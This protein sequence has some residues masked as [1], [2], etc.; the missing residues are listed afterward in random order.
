MKEGVCMNKFWSIFRPVNIK[1]FCAFFIPAIWLIVVSP[2]ITSANA[3][4]VTLAWNANSESNLAGYKLYYK[5][6]TG[7]APYNGTGLNEGDSPIIINLEDLTDTAS[8]EFPLTGLDKGELY[9]FALTAFD[10]DGL[11]SDYSEEVSYETETTGE[12]TYTITASTTGQGAVSPGGTVTATAGESRTFTISAAGNYHIADV[13]VDGTSV[14]QVGTYTF[15][16]INASHTI[17]AVF[18]ID[19]FTIT[20]TA[21][22]NG[23]IAPQGVTSA[24]YG[25]SLGYTITPADGC[26]ITDVLVD[27]TSVGQ[28]AAYSFEN[29]T[30]WHTISAV[31]EA[32]EIDIIDDGTGTGD[33]TGSDETTDET[34][35]NDP[36][37]ST[38]EE[39]SDNQ[40]GGNQ[41]PEIPAAL[42][43]MIEAPGVG[44]VEL[45]VGEFSDPDSGDSHAKTEWRIFREED[46][47]CI[48]SIA[49]TSSLTAFSVP[50]IMLEENSAYS[51][52]ARFF[53]N[54]N[55][56]SE[57]SEAAHFTTGFSAT[58]LDGNGIPDSQEVGDSVDMNQ[59]GI[60]DAEQEIVKSV[61]LPLSSQPIGLSIENSD[62]VSAI[63]FMEAVDTDDIV[64]SNI[65]RKRIHKL[66]YGLINFKLEVAEPGNS[67]TVTVH[68]SEPVHVRTK[69]MKFDVVSGVWYDYSGYSEISK[70]R[71]SIS[72]ELVDG[73]FGD[74]DGVA[75]GIIVD[76]SG[77]ELAVEDALSA[78]E[79][80][81]NSGTE[82]GASGCFITGVAGDASGRPMTAACVLLLLG[83]AAA[84]CAGRCS[85]GPEKSHREKSIA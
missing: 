59:D 5:T 1:I 6:D 65:N 20:A 2:L 19:T 74:D 25:S 4:E 32:D 14:G 66:P 63:L 7:G 33:G 34:T 21:G 10:T 64:V 83:I 75:N 79:D 42:S 24:A 22:E 58:D 39:T 16:N 84:T 18:E 17:S 67:A 56:A 81:T 78:E 9:F 28:V 27:G 13:A 12:T 43:D 26:H 41:S 36:D 77:L 71:M 76:P 40:D 55:A 31:F 85:G 51:W 46:G 8:P 37:E 62:T 49:S 72:I 61:M 38:G 47:V 15:N 53:D 44:P 57:W 48:L 82:S 23:S 29:I 45:A 70:D 73:G 30:T 52:Q 3:A 69:W 50:E 68:F 11:E 35:T 60:P 80:S 54:N